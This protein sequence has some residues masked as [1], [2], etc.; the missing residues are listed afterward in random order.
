MSI[1]NKRIA[2]YIGHGVEA[3]H[4][5][6]SSFVKILEKQGNSVVYLFSKRIDTEF[7]HEY[8]PVNQTIL[9]ED[10]KLGVK[11]HFIEGYVSAIRKARLKLKRVGLFHNFNDPK[12]PSF[13]R[14]WLLGNFLV[15]NTVTWISQFIYKQ[16]YT[17]NRVIDLFQTNGIEIL[18]LLDYNDPFQLKLG[19]SA[20]KANV[21]VNVCINSLKS[22]YINNFLPFKVNR[23]YVWNDFQKE[24][25]S[26]FNPN[27]HSHSI[28]SSGCFYHHFLIHDNN[29]YQPSNE[30]AEITRSPYVL[31]SLIFEDMYSEEY[32]LIKNLSETLKRLFPHNTPNIIIRRNPFETPH[33]NL[34]RILSIPGVF[35]APHNWE[36]D[37]EKDWSIQSIK[38][39][40][41]WKYLLTHALLLINISS[42]A[43][44]EALILGTPVINLGLGKNG[45]PEVL[46]N[47]FYK[48]PFMEVIHKSNFSGLVLNQG[49]LE[50]ELKRL[51][52][53]KNVVNKDA[54]SDSLAIIKANLSKLDI[55]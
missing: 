22:F 38:G 9:I 10:G 36:R 51:M 26:K 6:L 39:E 48:A 53:I 18:F 50:V 12:P 4:F 55:Y 15:H 2:F 7:R 45:N 21:K 49:E 47:R 30:I 3:R 17:D 8:F 24:L 25:F 42:M 46:L 54:I 33:F 14:D 31:Y 29:I 5:V 13:F 40:R 37:S 20:Q 44:I 41:E 1:E 43:S 27:I 35:L 32:Y 23:L 28:V 52:T 19:Y 34:N 16:H 11:R